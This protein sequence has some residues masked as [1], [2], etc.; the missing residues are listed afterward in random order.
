MR[1]GGLIAFAGIALGFLMAQA[2][3]AQQASHV[4]WVVAHPKMPLDQFGHPARG[5]QARRPAMLGRV[6]AKQLRQA[7]S[8]PQAQSG[9]WARVRPRRQGRRAAL[10]RRALPAPQ[11][12]TVHA[13]QT[14]QD[15]AGLLT[16]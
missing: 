10:L 5:P 1:D 6:L 2:Y 16:V 12:A 3:Q 7:S 4:P 9:P 8:L 13:H 15:P 11:R 14:G